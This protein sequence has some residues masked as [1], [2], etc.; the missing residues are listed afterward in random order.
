M[1]EPKTSPV[2]TSARKAPSAA[3]APEA[4]EPQAAP[5]PAAGGIPMGIGFV[6]WLVVTA[7]FIAVAIGFVT[8]AAPK[9]KT[10]PQTGSVASAEQ[11]VSAL[12]QKLAAYDQAGG[13]ASLVEVQ[14]LKT[15]F[16]LLKPQDTGVTPALEARLL[17]LET[18][19]SDLKSRADA[20]AAL[21]T[22]LA[23]LEANVRAPLAGPALILALDTLGR[24]AQQSHPFVAELTAVQ[25]LN[26]QL[27]GLSVLA[28][29]AAVGVPTRAALTAEFPALAAKAF[30]LARQ[31]VEGANLFEKFIYT[32][33]RFVSVRRT[34][35]ATGDGIDAILA[36]AEHRVHEG[37]LAAALDETGD[38]SGP[39]ADVLKDWREAAEA[40]LAVEAV[41][42]QIKTA[43]VASVM[44][45]PSGAVPAAA[46]KT[47]VQ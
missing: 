17:M 7:I 16:A 15:A 8:L 37:D 31:P 18:A 36:R 45:T 10:K 22:R 26:P 42:S 24:A 39:A 12:E 43:A 46:L 9:F 41:L 2:K 38:L 13:T 3:P 40:R 35:L 4:V 29:Y 1:R 44:G 23:T 25:Q 33:T 27:S 5:A 47:E 21:E 32:L 6:V 11:R 14:G 20:L 19:V 34:G 28:P 30:E